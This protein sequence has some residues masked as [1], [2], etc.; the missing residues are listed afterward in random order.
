MPKSHSPKRKKAQ[1]GHKPSGK[2]RLSWGGTYSPKKSFR[3][4]I[5]AVAV[6]AVVLAGVGAFW[7]RNFGAEQSIQN[8]A[9]EGSEFLSQV[10]ETPSLGQ[11]HLALGQTIEY[12]TLTPTSGD[13]SA[14]PTPPGFYTSPQP[15]SGNLHALEHGNI[16]IYYGDPGSEA[17]DQLKQWAGLYGGQLDGV[18]VTPQ[19]RLGK[20][21]VLTAWTKRLSLSEF[22]AAGAAAFIDAFRGRGP[23]A[24]VR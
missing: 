24:R 19:S 21:V 12:P 16:V 2:S 20:R 14:R 9:E 4:R 10:E 15:L 17:L 11:Q 22:D 1:K 7:W 18:V 13:H 23:E 6:V 8:L 5:V 3:D